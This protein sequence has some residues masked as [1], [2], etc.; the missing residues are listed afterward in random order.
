MVRKNLKKEGKNKCTVKDDEPGVD[1]NRNYDF[2]FGIDSFGSSI[3]PCADDYR[4][5][6]PF[7]EPA[8]KQ[9]KTFIEDTVEGQ[10]IKI[11]LNFHA[12]GNLLIHPFNYL[13]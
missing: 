9:M 8:T 7:S 12:Y 5:K 10:S 3:N 2:A 11:A 13:G 4:G 1:L 6:E